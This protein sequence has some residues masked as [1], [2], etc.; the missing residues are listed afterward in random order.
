MP[1]PHWLIVSLLTTLVLPLASA[2]RLPEPSRTVYKCETNGKVTYSDD[3]CPGA[4]RVD[5]QPTRG[6]NRSSGAE[7]VGTDVRREMQREQFAEALRPIAPIDKEQLERASR[8]FNLSPQ[9]KVECKAL[10][11]KL[12]HLEQAEQSATPQERSQ[13]QHQLLVERKRF[14]ELRC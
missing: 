1:Q 2:Q 4:Q 6:L 10:D 12:P 11:I 5:V 3:P 14:R 8:R 13:V 9:A 7:R